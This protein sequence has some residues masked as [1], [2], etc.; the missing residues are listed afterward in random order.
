V[1]ILAQNYIFF[2]GQIPVS[3]CDGRNAQI[4]AQLKQFMETDEMV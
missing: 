4:S 3:D 2:A 1:D